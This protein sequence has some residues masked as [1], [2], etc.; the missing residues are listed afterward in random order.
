MRRPSFAVPALLGA[1]LIGLAAM[2]G[3]RAPSDLMAAAR[4]SSDPYVYY[5]RCADARAAGA[6]PIHAGEPGY[7]PGLDADGD[8]VAC[9]PYRGR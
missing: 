8:G 3:V 7:R 2:Q 6:A 1:G 5:R 4:E 9:E